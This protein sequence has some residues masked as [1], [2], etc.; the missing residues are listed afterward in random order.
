[1]SINELTTDQ[2]KQHT[3]NRSMAGCIITEAKDASDVKNRTNKL[4]F[5]NKEKDSSHGYSARLV[6]DYKYRL[7][8]RF[9][10]ADVNSEDYYDNLMEL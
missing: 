9:I 3:F 10:A 4:T 1:M 6:R 8:L 2:Y 7:A 5:A